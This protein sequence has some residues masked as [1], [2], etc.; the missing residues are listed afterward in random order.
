LFNVQSRIVF[1][2]DFLCAE[3][4]ERDTGDVF[5]QSRKCRDVL[6]VVRG[7]RRTLA[8]PEI[9][10]GWVPARYHQA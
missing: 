8:G 7:E 3:T 1:N 9:A 10:R 6:H 2:R 4:L 5:L